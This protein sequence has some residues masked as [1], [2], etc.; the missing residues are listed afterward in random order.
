MATKITPG[1]LNLQN[2]AMEHD[3]ET[4]TTEQ[5]LHTTAENHEMNIPDSIHS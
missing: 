4:A 2:P 3:E 1:S 5:E